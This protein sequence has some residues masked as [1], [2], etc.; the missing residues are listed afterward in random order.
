MSV[1]ILEQKMHIKALVE[2]ESVAGAHYIVEMN[3]GV[4]ECSCPDF[5]N[6]KRDKGESCKHI[7]ETKEEIA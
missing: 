2:S 3:N 1:E 5:Q 7:D 4:W 6:R